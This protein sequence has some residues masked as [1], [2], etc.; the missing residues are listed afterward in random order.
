MSF[1]REFNKS[2]KFKYLNSIIFFSQTQLLLECVSGYFMIKGKIILNIKLHCFES[3]N[4]FKKN[5]RKS[6]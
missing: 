6:L 1:T 2:S 3:E 4:L 5:K